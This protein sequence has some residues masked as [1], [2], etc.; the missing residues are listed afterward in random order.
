MKA[1]RQ[2]INLDRKIGGLYRVH[3]LGR[4]INVLDISKVYKAGH[5]AHAEGRDV[6]QAIIAAVNLYTAPTI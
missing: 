6:E 5:T 3:A 2:Q 1:T 4:S